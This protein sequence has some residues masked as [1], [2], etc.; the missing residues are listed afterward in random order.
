MSDKL[1]KRILDYAMANR[2]RP[3]W[4]ARLYALCY[5]AGL[6]KLNSIRN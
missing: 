2:S 4:K 5:G 6:V 1:R 3:V